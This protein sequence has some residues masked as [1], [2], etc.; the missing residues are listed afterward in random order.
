MQSPFLEVAE[1]QRMCLGEANRDSSRTKMLSRQQLKE[2]F[3]LILDL[4]LQ[5]KI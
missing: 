1:M 4:V 3:N 5:G 2:L